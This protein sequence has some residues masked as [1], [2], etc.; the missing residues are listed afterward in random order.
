MTLED[1]VVELLERKHMTVTTAESCTAGLLS[2]RLMNVP[3]ASNVYNEGYITYSNQAKEKLLGVP[4]E[5]LETVGAVSEETAAAMAEGAARAANADA[6]L[7]VTGIAGPGG[8]TEEKPVGLVY[9]GC[10]VRG[11]IR[12]EKYLFTGNRNQNRESSV[13]NALTLLREELEGCV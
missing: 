9:I 12:V 1:S 2:G 8:G 10:Y 13:E 6:A 3:G 11:H 7:S 4:H 5:I